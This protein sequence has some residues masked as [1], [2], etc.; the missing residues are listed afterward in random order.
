MDL[1]YTSLPSQPHLSPHTPPIPC[2]TPHMDGYR[3]PPAMGT[4]IHSFIPPLFL[5]QRPGQDPPEPF[6]T[7]PELWAWQGCSSLMARGTWRNQRDRSL[8]SPGI[9]AAWGKA[10]EW[11]RGHRWGSLHGLHPTGGVVSSGKMI[12]A[13]S[14]C[15]HKR[16]SQGKG[17]SAALP[18]VLGQWGPKNCCHFPPIV[19][20]LSILSLGNMVTQGVQ[21]QRASA[22]IQ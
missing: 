15:E 6:P 16:L 10:A 22:E 5:L 8:L 2:S 7:F 11:G 9:L 4:P 17:G 18:H 1:K 19:S 14:L 21:M 12:A 3:P 13:P 20:V